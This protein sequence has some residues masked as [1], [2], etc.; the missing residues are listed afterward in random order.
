MPLSVVDAQDK[1]KGEINA[2]NSANATDNATNCRSK[3]KRN[4]DK[5]IR[6]LEF[7]LEILA[8]LGLIQE[9][10]KTINSFLGIG[11]K[12][13]PKLKKS[14]LDC[15][16]ANI[17][18]NL[19]DVFKP[20]QTYSPVINPNAPPYFIVKIQ[21]L[22]F[23]GLF[24]TNPSTRAGLIAYGQPSENTLNRTIKKAIDTNAI[25]NW[26]NIVW[27]KYNLGTDYLEFYID[28]KYANKPVNSFV[29]DL[30]NKISLIPNIGAMLGIFDNL[31]GAVSYGVQPTR[32]D[33]LSLI[34]RT[35][36]NKYVEKVL[37]GGD[38]LLIDESFFSFSNEELFDIE[39]IT[40][41]LSRNFLEITSCNNAESV[42]EPN[43][44]YPIMDQLVSAGTF[45]ERIQIIEAGMTTLEIN[46]SRNISRIDLPKFRAEFYFSIFREL[47]N[48]L[49]VFVYSPQLLII[50][51]IYLRLANTNA[52]NPTSLEVM[53]YK[54]FKDFLTKTRNIFKCIVLAYLKL[55]ILLIV[56]PIILKRLVIVV[57]EERYK[58]NMEKLK[59]YSEQYLAIKGFLEKVK[60]LQ[61][62]AEITSS[63]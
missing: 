14:L 48:T 46:A 50:M 44:L 20:S 4:N 39:R 9:F 47:L 31:Y 37:D 55:L 58:R 5:K 40:M 2:L 63:I 19:N 21:K 53:D 18:C 34:N 27:V 43:L 38:D 59:L 42:I 33:P 36:L 24:K 15:L 52:A 60:N 6:L 3:K 7:L 30:V 35:T 1:I 25:Q 12:Y 22:D 11:K 17:A 26:N 10:I 51:F 8:I 54:D 62:L 16:N 56:V 57:N 32:I 23:F 29:T 45:N 41:N 13:E 49:I 61:L 28:I